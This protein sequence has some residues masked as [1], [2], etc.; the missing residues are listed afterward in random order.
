M[1]SSE[2]SV[3]GSGN[4]ATAGW[5]T[6]RLL[7]LFLPL[8]L[9]S[10]RVLAEPLDL[11]DNTMTPGALNLAVTQAN[12]S[13]TICH[14]GWT[15]T[16]RPA[17]YYTNRLKRILLSA[18]PYKSDLPPSEFELDHRIPLELGGDPTSS[19]N[20]WP[21]PWI[22]SH[23]ARMKDRLENAVHRAVCTERITLAAGQAVFLGNWIEAYPLFVQK[24]A[25]K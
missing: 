5:V 7:V 13:S 15:S 24:P 11:P 2:C 8:V 20:L 17:V 1:K 19:F 6:T 18:Q 25:V 21:E 22:A 9:L 14:P 4:K 12:I 3:S 16:V 23:G 10:V